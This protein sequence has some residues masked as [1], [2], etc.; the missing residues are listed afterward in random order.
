MKNYYE[1]I[2]LDPFDVL[3]LTFH[4]KKGKSDPAYKDFKETFDLFSHDPTMKNVWIVKPGENTN[5]G[6]GIEVCKTIQ[7]VD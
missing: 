2:G 6:T 3:P 4:I 1:A 5:R 7:E